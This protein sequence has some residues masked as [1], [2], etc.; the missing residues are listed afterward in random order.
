MDRE[1]SRQPL[2]GILVVELAG[3][4]GSWAT[5]LLG[6]FGARVVKIARAGM[7]SVR[8]GASG[9]RPL[10]DSEKIRYA[11][12]NPFDR[13]KESIAVDLK[14]ETGRQI[15]YRLVEKSDIL[16]E[17]YRPGVAQRLGVD[18]QAVSKMNPKIIYCSITGYGQD[19]PYRD[20]PGHDINY[21][22]LSGFLGLTGTKDGPPAFPAIPVA[23][24]GG[25]FAQAVIGILLAVVARQHTGRG[26]F[27]DVAMCDGIVSWM[28]G[29]VADYLESGVVPKRGEAVPLGGAPYNCVYQTKDGQYIAIGCWEPWLY[30][31]LCRAIEH[32]ELIPLQH[33]EADELETVYRTLCE[34]FLTKTRDEWFHFLRSRDVC[35][36]PV[37]SLPEVLA[38]PQIVHRSM[39]VDVEHPQL[40]IIKQIGVGTKLSETPGSVRH[41]APMDGENTED[42]LMEIGYSKKQIE[43]LRKERV[44]S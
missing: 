32:E 37:N 28:K 11:A 14:K 36:A 7:P 2:D 4:P 3:P 41:T 19:G 13:N 22:A 31:N 40:G 24:W 5:G 44:I 10:T 29:W 21:S 35:V 16:V 9:M 12:Y 43:K 38:N 6:D 23:D 1:N 17:G 20:L 8:W 15:F 33:A 42:I 30:E 25:G 39:V 34:V 26:Q 27:I 18:Y